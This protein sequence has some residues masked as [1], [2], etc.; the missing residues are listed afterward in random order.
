MKKILYS[1]YVVI[2]IGI[3]ISIINSGIFNSENSD[4]IAAGEKVYQK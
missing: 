1:L 2:I 4:A 3:I